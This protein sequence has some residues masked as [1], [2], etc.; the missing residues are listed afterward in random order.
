MSLVQFPD[1]QGKPVLIVL[2]YPSN[3]KIMQIINAL[4]FSLRI[5][6]QSSVS[7]ELYVS[8]SYMKINV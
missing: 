2:V 4:P 8:I 1:R 3:V 6:G 7:R 5:S